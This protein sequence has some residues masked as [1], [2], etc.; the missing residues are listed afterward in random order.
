MEW[1]QSDN[2]P[3]CRWTLGNHILEVRLKDG[4]W[5]PCKVAFRYMTQR[6]WARIPVAG[7]AKKRTLVINPIV[8]CLAGGRNKLVAAKAYDM[9]NAKNRVHGIELHYPETIHDV[10]KSEVPLWVESMGGI[11]VVKVPYGN[12]GQGVYT[13]TKP[14]DLKAFMEEDTVYDAYI[15]QSL[16]GNHAWSS[17]TKSGQYYHVG[18]VPDKQ[19]DIYAGDLR[20]QISYDY[21]KK[22]WRPLAAYSRRALTP[23]KEKLDGTQDSWSMLG[24]NLSVKLEGA[25]SWTTDTSRLILMDSRDFNK[26]GISVDDLIDAFMQSVFATAAIDNLAQRLQAEDSA[27]DFDLFRSLNNDSALLNEILREVD[28]EE[29]K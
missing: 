17:T 2:D 16:V 15:V 27:F 8:A 20:M 13:I 18:M 29:V 28:E 6:P 19:N 11:A 4:Q 12:A 9:F 26:L 7:S 25:D 10:R 21:S 3:P 1:K 14:E 22:A 5:V 24:T 23:L